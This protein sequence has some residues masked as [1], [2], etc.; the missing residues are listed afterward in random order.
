MKEKYLGRIRRGRPNRTPSP[1]G[2]SMSNSYLASVAWVYLRI[3]HVQMEIPLL[4][5][6][7]CSIALL[8]K[9]QQQRMAGL[10]KNSLVKG[11]PIWLHLYLMVCPAT[12]VR[13][14]PL[15]P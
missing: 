9:V 5:K 13:V 12:Q 10:E 14:S 11:I 3:C 2:I 4:L 1:L 6:P 8:M 15:F 7:L